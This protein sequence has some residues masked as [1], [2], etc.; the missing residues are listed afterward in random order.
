LEA[1]SS[2]PASG[3]RLVV[4]RGASRSGRSSVLRALQEKHPE[5]T[6]V[7]VGTAWLRQTP[8]ALLR[9]S[10]AGFDL[11]T[12]GADLNRSDMEG[13]ITAAEVLLS[14]LPTA[15]Q[16]PRII[17]VDDAALSD[18]ASLQVLTL[19]ARR[20]R[21]SS[22]LI[23]IAVSPENMADLD[24]DFV[25]LLADPMNLAVDIPALQ[26]DD[27]A[28]LAR[29]QGMTDI[30]D[31]EA[32]MLLQYS[33]GRLTVLQEIMA[34]LPEGAFPTDHADVP[35]PPSVVQEVLLPL[36]ETDSPTLRNLVAALTVLGDTHDLERLGHV[37]ATGDDTSRAVDLGLSCGVL[38]ERNT[39]GLRVL[40][41]SHPAAPRVVS[42]DMLP[43]TRRALHRR[44]A[45][46]AP[47]PEERLCHLAEAAQGP[48][49][50]LAAAL[51][52]A[53]EVAE[54]R[55]RWED[56]SRLKFSAVKVL[57]PSAERD[58]QLLSG[59]DA[60]ASAGHVTDLLP[61]LEAG[62][63]VPFSQSR[64]AVLANVAI[65]RGKAAEADDLLSRA[66][67]SDALTSES[68]AH[69]ALRRTL[70]ALSRWDG[71][72]LCSW[73]ARAMDLSDPEEPA[74]VESLAMRGV[75]LAAQGDFRE[76][77]R[78]ID[79]I[80][81][82]SALGAQKQRFHLCNGW[83][84]LR[85]GKLREAVRELEAAVPTRY[86]RGSMRISLW[87][88][89]W[90]ARTQYLLGEWDDALR[91]ADRGLT[92]SSAAG[93]A[94][95]SPLLHWT[96]AEIRLWRGHSPQTV[97][98]RATNGASLSDYLAMQVP[99]RLVRA[100]A[101]NV[102]GDHLGRAAA[103]QPLLDVDPWTSE[104]T[105]FWPWHAELV[106][107]LI[108]VG[109]DRE[110]RRASD[111]MM[112]LADPSNR[113]V[114]ALA[115]TSRARVLGAQ[116]D[117][118][119]AEKRFDEAS[120]LLGQADDQPTTQA[121][122]LLNRGQMLR[123]ANRRREAVTW[124]SRAREFYEGVGA[125]VLIDRCDRE[126]RATGMSGHGQDAGSN[127]RDEPDVSSHFTLTPQEHAV[128]DLVA[129]GMTNSEVAQKLFIAE[130]TVQYHLTNVY[131]KFGIRS[132]TE[133]A[134][135]WLGDHGSLP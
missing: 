29:R 69:V 97:M 63:E 48:D 87:A 129:Q 120:Q 119:Q 106:D 47:E 117:T 72:Q 112:A 75:G 30:G 19:V 1:H 3:G 131:A 78:T 83:V 12:S 42:D 124:L 125:T 76:A 34:A 15:D 94:L 88:R 44:A 121:Q 101:A 90:L 18:Q 110:A 9:Q 64:D 126:L 102:R 5:S 128:S 68:D 98:R 95:V 118:G 27:V 55:G 59:I 31:H 74:H 35:L 105:S 14:R 116:G 10:T 52:D 66:S 21:H 132:R 61:W 77:E 99:A 49:L 89:G 109:R 50:D 133:L 65:H 22:A 104:R 60:L 135:R 123:R 81:R 130:K 32:A 114:Y 36:R 92:E 28:E 111:Q 37:A 38:T 53:A 122:V 73:A 96:A 70:D 93:I 56:S 107:A 2:V 67:A 23:V 80:A 40:G 58:R 86:E 85:Q 82:R 54:R 51:N 127:L 46:T 25:R 8:Y 7:L 84:L 11:P 13:Q 41:F 43:S 103:L 100:V 108:A 62:K 17:A 115:L 39:A 20:I 134:S 6:D 79:E 33:G 57:P 91:T 24:P 113:H 45:D 71:Q 16:E 26:I 4:L